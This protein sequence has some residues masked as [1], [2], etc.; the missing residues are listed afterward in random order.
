M[1]CKYGY[2][3]KVKDDVKKLNE[4]LS[5]QGSSLLL[6]AIA[7]HAGTTA[8]VFKMPDHERETLTKSLVNELKEALLERV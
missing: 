8:N 6:D 2:E 5:R 4:I 1:S 3:E 7:E